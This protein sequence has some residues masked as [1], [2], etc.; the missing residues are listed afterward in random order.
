VTCLA[1]S[2]H[3]IFELVQDGTDLTCLSQKVLPHELLIPALKRAH[4]R[5]LHYPANAQTARLVAWVLDRHIDQLLADGV[6]YWG[7]GGRLCVAGERIGPTH[8]SGS[9][10]EFPKIAFA[11]GAYEG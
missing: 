2:R 3:R 6:I 7:R 9:W 5:Y 11:R 4:D 8:S 10:A 1:V